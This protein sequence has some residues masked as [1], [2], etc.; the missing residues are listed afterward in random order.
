M[1]KLLLLSVLV[2]APALEGE[3]GLFSN[4]AAAAA[5]VPSEGARRATRARLWHTNIGS[6]SPPRIIMATRRD[7]LPPTARL[8]RSK[9][10]D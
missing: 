4:Q 7:C 3:S 6:R 1:K 2:L 8:T 10:K 5:A 9:R